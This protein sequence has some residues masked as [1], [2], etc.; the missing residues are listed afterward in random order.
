MAV[1]ILSDYVIAKFNPDLRWVFIGEEEKAFGDIKSHLPENI[2]KYCDFV[3]RLSEFCN[4]RSEAELS[5]KKAAADAMMF[6][7]IILG[8]V[9]EPYLARLYKLFFHLKNVGFARVILIGTGNKHIEQYCGEL[10]VFYTVLSKKSNEC[11]KNEKN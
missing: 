11:K 5:V 3:V 1:D 7:L 2:L 6:N 9:K 4:A 8:E 10:N